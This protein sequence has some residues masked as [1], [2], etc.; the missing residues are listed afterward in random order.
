MDTWMFISVDVSGRSFL[1][2]NVMTAVVPGAERD[3]WSWWRTNVELQG[4]R[5][6]RAQI[7]KPEGTLVETVWQRSPSRGVLMRRKQR[8]D[9]KLPGEVRSRASMLGLKRDKEIT[10]DALVFRGAGERRDWAVR[11]WD[12][13]RRRRAEGSY[14][15][16]GGSSLCVWERR[17]ACRS[18]QPAALRRSVFASLSKS[19][20]WCYLPA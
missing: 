1:P 11:R 8:A 5:K 9:P 4:E 15:C 13:E 20:D 7:G 10:S 14:V 12:K 3:P 16:V 6:W 19:W 17:D 18:G 2:T